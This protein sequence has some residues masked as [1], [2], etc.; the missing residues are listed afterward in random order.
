LDFAAVFLFG[1]VLGVR[2]NTNSA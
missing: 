1:S 2:G